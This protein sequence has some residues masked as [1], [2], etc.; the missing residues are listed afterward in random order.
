MLLDIDVIKTHDLKQLINLAQPKMQDIT[1]IEDC[2]KLNDYAVKYRY[3]DHFE[4]N[5][6]EIAKEAL[7]LAKKVKA[8][9]L[10]KIR[11]TNS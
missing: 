5:D 3:P 2:V 10:Q 4:V 6:I 8:F 9:V 1:A 11:E 7:E